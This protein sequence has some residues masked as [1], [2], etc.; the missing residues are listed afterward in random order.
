M[1]AGRRDYVAGLAALAVMEGLREDKG[2]LVTA[3]QRGTVGKI[4]SK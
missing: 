1:L 3:T 4:S 2:I